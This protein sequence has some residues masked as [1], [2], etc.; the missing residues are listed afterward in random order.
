MTDNRVPPI[1]TSS[2]LIAIGEARY[3][4]NWKSALSDETGWSYWTFYRAARGTI[5][6]SP[7]MENAIRNLKP[8]RK[9]KDGLQNAKRDR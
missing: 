2:E 4:K 9:G 5:E 3:G 7:K 1:M 8:K 6:V